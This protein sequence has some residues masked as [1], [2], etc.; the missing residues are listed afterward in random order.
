RLG[1]QG[2]VGDQVNW[3][4]EFDFAG[5]AISFKDVYVGLK[6]LPLIKRLRVGHMLE[7]FSLEGHTSSNYFPFVERSPSLALYPARNW[8]VG[9][10]SYTND[11][12]ATLSAAIFRDG[13]SSNSGNDTSGQNDMA[14]DVRTTWLPWYDVAS[15]RRHLLALDGACSQ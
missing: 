5:A 8:G 10:F 11:E 6:E 4:A 1:A 13:S 12:R 3:V 14:Y 7:P 2:T 9:F 15:S